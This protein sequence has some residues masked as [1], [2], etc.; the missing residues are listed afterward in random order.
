MSEYCVNCAT[1]EEKCR[2]LEAEANRLK[3]LVAS[4]EALLKRK[5]V[6]DE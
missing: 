1:T 5:V 2:K 4:Y 3:S 6:G